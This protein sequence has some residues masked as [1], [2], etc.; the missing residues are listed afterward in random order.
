MPDGS[1][2]RIRDKTYPSDWTDDELRMYCKGMITTPTPVNVVML[3]ARLR[4]KVPDR[5]NDDQ[6]KAFI[7]TGVLP[8]VV[9]PSID[10]LTNVSTDEYVG[11]LQ[12][13]VKS[14]L[15]EADV[16]MAI[17]AHL[18]IDPHWTDDHIYNYY[19]NG[20]KPK[21]ATTGVLVEDRLR[22]LT[23]P[24]AWSWDELKA[25]ALG[26]VEAVFDLNNESFITRV[27]RL[28]SIQ[29]GI[30]AAHWSNEEVVDY[31]RSNVKP[32]ALEDGV[33][34]ND[35]TRPG[36][37]PVEWRDAELR[38]WL[39]GKIDAT[40]KA[41]EEDLWEEI[42]NRFKITPFWYRE[43]ARS[44]VLDGKV[45]PS[46]PSGLY[47]RDRNRDHRK[48]EHW[49]RREIKAWARG[50][51]LPGINADEAALGTRAARLFNISL[52][53]DTAS[54]KKRIADI[55]EESTTMTV[56]FVEEDLKS[57]LKG[58]QDAG[59]NGTAAAP[60]QTLLDRC[61][62]RV[63]RLQG[64]DF[65]Q[66]WT[67]LLNFFHEH[68]KTIMSPKKIYTGV[69]QMSITSKGLRNFQNMTTILQSTAN[70]E[71]RDSAV[72]LI[73]WK[74]ALKEVSSETARQGIFAYYG[75]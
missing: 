55:K 61:I 53:L 46:T 32:I 19:R 8:E 62:N 64:E 67:T 42:Y 9:L 7:L 49:T 25:F 72:R 2:D 52:Q 26:E 4:F 24:G 5:C 48:I 71:G 27:R 11:Y 20:V 15:S 3:A 23:S 69:G 22:D 50:Q 58:R 17:R 56:K 28:I 30:G 16:L 70:P 10:R 39:R 37:T 36:K 12:G 75:L 6:A 51:I 34:I 54:I 18:G 40:D 44:Y 33:Y 35:P 59:D 60:Y 1:R 47:T 14:S 21:A 29:F 65:V 31:L 68:S 74:A 38:A 43:D 13:K 41:S 66:G 73:D 57:Y 63:L 45:V